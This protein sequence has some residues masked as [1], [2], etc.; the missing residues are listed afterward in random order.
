MCL[1][2]CLSVCVCVRAWGRESSCFRNSRTLPRPRIN[3][4]SLI[5]FQCR[6]CDSCS[7][8]VLQL[9]AAPDQKRREAS[10]RVWI[11]CRSLRRVATSRAR[12]VR[13]C[14]RWRRLTFSRKG[15]PAL[16]PLGAL[17]MDAEMN[18]SVLIYHHGH[19]RAFNFASRWSNTTPAPS[20]KV[21]PMCPT[22][23]TSHFLL[24]NDF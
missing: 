3:N 13:V 1:P 19:R 22:S 18:L 15:Q 20:T 17:S 11:C 6:A 14:N 24:I 23:L 7:M 2:A 10:A 5:Y 9:S 21:S 12:P 8:D 4:P 16:M